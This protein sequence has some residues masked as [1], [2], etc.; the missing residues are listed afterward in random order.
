[1]YIF[2]FSKTNLRIGQAPLIEIYQKL[3]QLINQNRYFL[4]PIPRSRVSSKDTILNCLFAIK[5]YLQFHNQAAK[6]R[7]TFDLNL[8]G[9]TFAILYSAKKL[10]Q[11]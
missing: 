9:L 4:F 8:V 1:M 2:I 7:Q 5:S 11:S 6:V 3:N 10:H